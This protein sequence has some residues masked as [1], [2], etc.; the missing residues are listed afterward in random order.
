MNIDLLM[1]PIPTSKYKNRQIEKNNRLKIQ[2]KISMEN[3]IDSNN[4]NLSSSF[5]NINNQNEN[6]FRKFSGYNL[7]KNMENNEIKEG[8]IRNIK[9]PRY[10]SNSNKVFQADYKKHINILSLKNYDNNSKNKNNSNTIPNENKSYSD[11][12]NQNDINNNIFKNYRTLNRRNDNNNYN[13]N[14]FTINSYNN[15]E[16]NGNYITDYEKKLSITDINAPINNE[17]INNNNKIIN[18]NENEKEK[19]KKKLIK[20]NNLTSKEKAY[21][22]LSKSPVLPLSSQIIFSRSSENV[23]NI[24]S[25]KEI[26]QNNKSYLNNKIE[27][28]ENK[29]TEYNKQI[30]SVFTASKIAE[31]NLNFITNK[32]EEEFS[33]IYNNLLHNKTEYDFIYYKNYIKIIYYII[34]ESFEE[35]KDDSISD[36]SDNKLLINLY[37]ILKKK[38]YDNI[39]DYLYFLYISSENKKKENYFMKNLDKINDI[40]NKEVPSLLSIYE[41]FKT[42][43]FIMFSFFLIKEIIDYGNNIKNIIKL[44]IET[45]SFLEELKE[46]LDRFKTKF[47]K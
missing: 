32:S 9:I 31:I 27:D 40:I 24:I 17:D 22:L 29:I 14:I 38:Q 11:L 1:K 3:N 2:K 36:I 39:K 13:S 5:S 23:K 47:S 16:T 21:Y 42:C 44:E 6:N 30:T 43:K 15:K 20:N 37:S 45:K 35:N 4:N 10:N 8:S 28:Y 34:D 19:E 12:K 26:L 33:E 46:N 25:I 7:K 41:P 18:K